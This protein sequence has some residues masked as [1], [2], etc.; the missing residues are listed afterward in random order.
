MSK[1]RLLSVLLVAM[2]LLNAILIG[3]WLWTKP[4]P[5]RINPKNIIIDRL[6]FDAA[7][8]KIYKEL[9]EDH[10]SSI[11]LKAD[12]M[13]LAKNALFTSLTNADDSSKTRLIEEIGSIK[14]EIE[15]IHYMH[16]RDISNICRPDQRQ[17]FYNLTKEMADL[18]GPP[19]H[20][21]K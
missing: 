5:P 15:N 21:P 16:F 17:Q 3:A 9:I 4:S 1:V 10:K 6:D 18:F 12:E 19:P 8:I 11:K 7:Q 2:V 13:K 14:Q 20:P